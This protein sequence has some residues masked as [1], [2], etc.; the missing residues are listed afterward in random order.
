MEFIFDASDFQRAATDLR[1]AG[2]SLD[3]EIRP[4]LSKGALNVKNQLQAEARRSRHFRI[5]RHIS[6]DL[7]TA[8][9]TL[10]AE[11]GP[12]AVGAG[13]L[14]GAYFGWSN[15]GGGTLP[16]PKGAL[17]AEGPRFEDAI[18]DILDRLLS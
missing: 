12:E 13:N 16:D 2:R 17:E 7:R 9:G 3:G 5:E 15:G 6:Y 1:A 11:I 18:G 14:L 8:G 10:E 4:A